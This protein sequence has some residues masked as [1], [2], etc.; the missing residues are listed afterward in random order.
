MNI[1]EM[2]DVMRADPFKSFAVHYPSGKR[3]V[4]SSQDQAILSGDKRTLMLTR[5][6]S[7]VEGS[8]VDL[9]DVALAEHVEM[10]PEPIKERMWWVSKNGH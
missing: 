6:A 10:L 2:Y 4:I 1:N 7:S 5:S 9:I 8:G 3:F